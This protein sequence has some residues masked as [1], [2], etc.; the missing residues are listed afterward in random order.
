VRSGSLRLLDS[1]AGQPQSLCGNVVVQR[2]SEQ[3]IWLTFHPQAGQ[4]DC[5]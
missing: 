1:Q 4:L 3:Q 2:P 5:R